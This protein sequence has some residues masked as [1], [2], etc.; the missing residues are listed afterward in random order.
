MTGARKK[1][2]GKRAKMKKT[3][4][5]KAPA[6]K[7]LSSPP[8]VSP[9]GGAVDLYRMRQTPQLETVCKEVRHDWA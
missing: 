3:R 2:V 8:T 9:D 7:K 4:T 1:F 6:T 5:P